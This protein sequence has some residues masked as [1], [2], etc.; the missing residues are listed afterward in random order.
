MVRGLAFA[1]A[2]AMFYI[3]GF[4][5]LFRAEEYR[6]RLV[7][8]SGSELGRKLMRTPSYL[9]SMRVGGAIL[10]I[11]A[12]AVTCFVVVRALRGR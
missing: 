5:M 7:K 3:M 1:V 2:L 4:V 10:L 12:L 11:G 9:W 8:G 6:D